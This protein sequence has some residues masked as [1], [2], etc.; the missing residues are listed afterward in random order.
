LG[1]LTSTTPNVPRPH[2]REHE[3]DDEDEDADAADDDG[4]EKRREAKNFS[5]V[6]A[7]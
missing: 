3:G 4:D 1:R 5:L 7:N 2:G 6:N